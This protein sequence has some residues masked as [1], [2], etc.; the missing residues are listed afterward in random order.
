MIVKNHV[1]LATGAGYIFLWQ[2]VQ[3]EAFIAH[4]PSWKDNK[5][6]AYYRPRP[7]VLP[8]SPGSH[9]VSRLCWFIYKK[10]AGFPGGGGS[11]KGIKSTCRPLPVKQSSG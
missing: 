8:P 7:Y 5:L 3:K 4:R 6:L 10:T 11:L 9:T 1:R 2:S